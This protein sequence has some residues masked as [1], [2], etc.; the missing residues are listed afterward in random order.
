M[1]IVNASG[2]LAQVA[3]QIVPQLAEAFLAKFAFAL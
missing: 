1:L 3:A 2:Y